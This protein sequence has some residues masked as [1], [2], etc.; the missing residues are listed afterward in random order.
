[1]QVVKDK[2]AEFIYGFAKQNCIFTWSVSKV[3]L[4]ESFA[5]SINVSSLLPPINKKKLQIMVQTLCD[6][7]SKLILIVLENSYSN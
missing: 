4:M 7:I 2:F 3:A 6:L 5:G 1:M